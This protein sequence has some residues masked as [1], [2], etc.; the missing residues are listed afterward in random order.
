MV[1]SMSQQRPVPRVVESRPIP[2]STFITNAAEQVTE[3]T[4][5]PNTLRQ[6]ALALKLLQMQK[7]KNKAIEDKKIDVLEAKY[8]AEVKKA[9]ENAKRKLEQENLKAEAAQEKERQAA[10]RREKRRHEAELNKQARA[11]T[12]Q[13]VAEVKKSLSEKKKQ[14]AAEQKLLQKKVQEEEKLAKKNQQE[15]ERAAKRARYSDK[16]RETEKIAPLT[17]VQ[18]Q[19]KK[20]S[21]FD[22]FRS[23]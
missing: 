6:G 19:G 13:W 10:E 4:N 5:M 1:N 16:L 8:A 17:Q 20:V 12:K 3:P 15:E 7:D 11:E 9:E 18:T 14:E 21:M 2:S 23:K 22:E